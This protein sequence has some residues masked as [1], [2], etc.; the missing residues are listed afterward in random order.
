MIKAPQGAFCFMASFSICVKAS[1]QACASAHGLDFARA[2]ISEGH[3][4]ARVFFYGDGVYLGLKTQ[5]TPQGE[6]SV[7]EH[8]QRFVLQHQIDAVVCIAAAVRRGVL[9][10]V[11]AARHGFVAN[12]RE[13]FS[14]SGLGQWVAANCEA[15]HVVTF[16]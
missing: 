8:W 15:D 16:G 14:L 7:A 5:V 3:N 4:I 10:E 11:E 9:D 12:L 6:S 2:C 1:P 13:G